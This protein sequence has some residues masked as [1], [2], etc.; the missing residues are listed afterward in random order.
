[1]GNPHIKVVAA[2]G[3]GLGPNPPGTVTEAGVPHPS[4]LPESP[5]DPA[6]LRAAGRKRRKGHPEHDI[7]AAFFVHVRALVPFIPELLLAHAPKNDFKRTG[8]EKRDIA[9]W[10][11]LHAEGVEAG[12]LDV[13]IPLS[14]FHGSNFWLELKAPGNTPTPKQLEFMAMA[15]AQGQFANWTDSLDQAITWFDEHMAPWLTARKIE[16]P[17]KKR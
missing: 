3:A 2:H 1:M 8:N 11:Y 14:G 16:L 6:V 7:Q 10:A 9:L 12:V 5:H 13:N 4:V 17:A 15:R